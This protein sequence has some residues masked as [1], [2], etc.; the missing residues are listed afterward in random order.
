[1]ETMPGSP[2]VSE[3]SGNQELA[4]Q[5]SEK[6]ERTAAAELVEVLL[7]QLYKYIPYHTFVC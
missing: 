5:P 6:A 1:M 3:V 2:P 4:L 7:Q